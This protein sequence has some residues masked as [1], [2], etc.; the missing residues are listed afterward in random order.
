MIQHLLSVPPAHDKRPFQVF[1]SLFSSLGHVNILDGLTC[2]RL[3]ERDPTLG[4]LGPTLRA[5]VGDTIKVTLKNNAR[6]TTGLHPHGVLYSKSSEGS[7]YDD[8][9]GGEYLQQVFLDSKSQNCRKRQSSCICT[10]FCFVMELRL[11]DL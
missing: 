7:P 4:F 2:W 9:T 6:F 11:W 5:K 8:G 10:R 1:V 3:Q